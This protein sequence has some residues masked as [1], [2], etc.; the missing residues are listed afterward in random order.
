MKSRP[1]R[2]YFVGIHN[3]PGLTPLCSST[4]SGKLIDGVIAAIKNP[5]VE[6]LKTNLYDLDYLPESE[7]LKLDVTKWAERVGYDER[8]DTAITLGDKVQKAF[9]K[10]R[11]KDTGD[12]PIMHPAARW[13]QK[14]KERYIKSAV[15]NLEILL[16]VRLTKI[17]LEL[18]AVLK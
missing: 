11:P 18:C 4:R 17:V 3:K 12:V 8:F 10:W 1:P 16:R 6:I 14:N 15:S 7:N 13:S 5:H 9:K 2:I